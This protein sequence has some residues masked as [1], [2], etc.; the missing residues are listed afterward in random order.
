MMKLKIETQ[1]E[2]EQGE[3]FYLTWASNPLD[4]CLSTKLGFGRSKDKLESE[5]LA[6][7]DFIAR[8]ALDNPTTKTVE[9]N[10]ET[11][12]YK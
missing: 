7:N 12:E 9:L 5:Q 2:L 10:V 6:V 4:N 1:C 8:M 3:K 11:G